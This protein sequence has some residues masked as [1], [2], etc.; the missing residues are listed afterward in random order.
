MLDALR[1]AHRKGWLMGCLLGKELKLG[2]LGGERK[3]RLL[4]LKEGK[5]VS[6]LLSWPKGCPDR[7]RKTSMLAG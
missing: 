4:Q 3:Q 2:Y 6:A 5:R 7:P 1:G